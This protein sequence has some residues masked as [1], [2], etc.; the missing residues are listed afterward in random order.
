M[1]VVSVVVRG[2]L[3]VIVGSWGVCSRPPS[4]VEPQMREHG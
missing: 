2:V 1:V 4:S 3:A